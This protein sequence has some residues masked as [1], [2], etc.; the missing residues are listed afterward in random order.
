VILSSQATLSEFLLNLPTPCFIGNQTAVVGAEAGSK[1][2]L[3]WLC[4]IMALAK[5]L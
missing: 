5:G 3:D 2:V 4:N 1:G